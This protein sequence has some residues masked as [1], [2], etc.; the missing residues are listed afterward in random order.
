MANEL[1]KFADQ[2]ATLNVDNF[3]D[4]IY[5]SGVGGT[6]PTYT[7]YL[8]N[9]AQVQTAKEQVKAN[10]DNYKLLIEKKYT[11]LNAQLD[12]IKSKKD[13]YNISIKD[14]KVAEIKYKAGYLSA[15]DYETQKVQLDALQVEYLEQIF[16]Y[17]ELKT[18]V[19]KPWVMQS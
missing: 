10:Y 6:G 8:E 5:Q 1:T 7:T 19:E 4:T 12:A 2:K 14:M 3:W 17:D 13:S 16:K 11:E 9:K 18:Q 15:I